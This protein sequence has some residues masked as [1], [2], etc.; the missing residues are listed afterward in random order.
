MAIVYET[1]QIYTGPP[2]NIH[3]LDPVKQWRKHYENYKYLKFIHDNTKDWREKHQANKELQI[4]QRKMDRWYN[5]SKTVLSEI[6]LARHEV[7]QVW[8]KS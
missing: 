6:E 2:I 5:M 8:A 4:A 3:N 1:E 7:D